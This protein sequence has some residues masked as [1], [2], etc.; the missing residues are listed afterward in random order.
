MAQSNFFCRGSPETLPSRT[1]CRCC[2]F[3][4]LFCW[5]DISCSFCKNE[6]LVCWSTNPSGC[7]I[8]VLWWW[9]TGACSGCCCCLTTDCGCCWSADFVCCWTEDCWLCGRPEHGADCVTEISMMGEVCI[10]DCWED[11]SWLGCNKVCCCCCCCCWAWGVWMAD[12]VIL[13]CLNFWF[14][15]W[16][17]NCCS[18]QNCCG[19]WNCRR[20]TGCEKSSCSCTCLQEFAVLLEDT[21]CPTDSITKLGKMPDMLC[22]LTSW[23]TTFGLGILVKLVI[24]G[25]TDDKLIELCA[26]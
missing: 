16:C 23:P 2:C 10:T 5:P 22:N 11:N 7:S 19:F 25:T 26:L 4:W 12:S 8:T 18:Q 6:C 9:I 17:C 3:D 20:A 21:P 1:N 14:G 15:I 24:W 13:S